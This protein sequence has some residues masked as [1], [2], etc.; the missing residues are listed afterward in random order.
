[1]RRSGRATRSRPE[2]LVALLAVPVLLACSGS[3]GPRPNVLVLSIDCLNG[4]QLAGAVEHS[5]APTLGRIAGDAMVFDR[6]Y[7]H[8]PWTNPSHMSMLTGLYP[9]QHGR[10]I[11]FHLMIEFNEFFDRTPE[12]ETLPEMLSAAGY[13]TAAFVGSGP[14][15]AAFGLGPGVRAVRRDPEEQATHRSAGH[16]GRD[17]RVVRGLGRRSLLP[18]RSHIRC[19]QPPAQRLHRRAAS[20]RLRR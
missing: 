12:F 20:D 10:D 9:S 6:A 16:P 5:L 15:A 1:M 4:R 14:T 17:R 8:A 11:P 3:E 18:V 13:A 2:R 19:P 7:A